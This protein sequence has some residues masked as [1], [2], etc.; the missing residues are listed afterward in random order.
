MAF[1]LEGMETYLRLISDEKPFHLE[2]V[3]QRLERVKRHE[4]FEETSSKNNKNGRPVTR[5]G[6]R[7]AFASSH[8][9]QRSTV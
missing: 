8:R 3:L 7:G 2:F 9:P 1:S 6:A 4:Y 5:G